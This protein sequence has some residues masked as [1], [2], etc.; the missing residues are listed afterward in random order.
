M[1]RIVVVDDQPL[2]GN[3]YRTKFAA[4]GFHVD[5]AV[6]G[7]QALELIRRER[8]DLVLLDVVIPKIDG[9]EVLRRLRNESSFR[10]LPIIV[11][12]GSAQAGV[13]EEAWAA[14]ATNVLSKLSTS[15]KK[16]VELV[17]QALENSSR[18]NPQ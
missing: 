11:F 13:L 3:I 14:G 1:K 18:E 16:L 8:P 9:L 5:V 7:Q 15:P 12:S 10:T 2:L 4:E 6:D 17:H